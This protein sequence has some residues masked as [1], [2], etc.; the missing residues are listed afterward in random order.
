[1]SGRHTLTLTLS[2]ALL[3]VWLAAPV[4]AQGAPTGDAVAR[5]LSFDPVATGRSFALIVGNSDYIHHDKLPQ[6]A[7]DARLVK[8]A[9][10]QH[11]GFKVQ[12]RLNLTSDKLEPALREFL[13]D[14]GDDPNAR[15][16]IWF[17]GHGF[18]SQ[19]G[20]DKVG[21]IVPVDAPAGNL[22]TNNRELRLKSMD[23]TPIRRWLRQ[24]EARHVL[25]VFDSCFSGALLGSRSVTSG[26][27]EP[28]PP[29]WWEGKVRH[30]VASGS[31]DDRVPEDG[32]F[33]RA[34]VNAIT[35]PVS[36]LQISYD[37]YVTITNL[38]QHV[39]T[40][41]ALLRPQGPSP[42]DGKVHISADLREGEFVFAL[43]DKAIKRPDPP[44]ATSPV[45]SA[46][47]ATAAVPSSQCVRPVGPWGL[48]R[49]KNDPSAFDNF[50][51][52][53]AVSGRHPDAVRSAARIVQA[54]DPAR[55]SVILRFDTGQN[56]KSG[57]ADLLPTGLAISTDQSVRTVRV[58][59][60]R[61]IVNYGEGG[62]AVLVPVDVPGAGGPD[63]TGGFILQGAWQ[64]AGAYGCAEI[65]LNMQTGIGTVLK[66]TG[67]RNRL[68]MAV[69]GVTQTPLRGQLRIEPRSK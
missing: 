11:H 2:A 68:G 57:I 58:E 13:F 1:M 8:A 39:K 21:F 32:A 19:L 14:K 60:E 41:L 12:L 65:R 38:V 45:P 56:V 64:R 18:T 54:V 43:P 37:R 15:L 3:W 16:L 62:R 27:V 30:I 5:Q 36:G 26:G 55:N 33:A 51:N 29:T 46:P 53:C 31:V 66:W 47:A 44:A 42:R 67:M 6:V 22:A 49:A 52:C 25:L 48:A 61:L 50:V 34:F 7:E 17:A 10:E 28:S 35:K 63:M 40:E 20:G 69:P 9:L 23:V 4:M 24:I 59:H